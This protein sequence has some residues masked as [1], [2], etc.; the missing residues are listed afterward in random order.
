MDANCNIGCPQ[1]KTQTIEQGNK[2]M[3]ERK[4]KEE[5]DGWLTE[6]PGGM[7]VE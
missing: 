1:L 7:L 6:L 3:Q 4:V 2:C 5:I